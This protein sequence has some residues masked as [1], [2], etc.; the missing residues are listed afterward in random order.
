MDS[1]ARTSL[2]THGEAIEKKLQQNLAEQI[3]PSRL[4]GLIFGV[5]MRTNKLNEGSV[6]LLVGT[7]NDLKLSV[8]DQTKI[9]QSFETAL[10]QMNDELKLQGTK[11]QYHSL[12]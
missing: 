10:K 5:D 4:K 1:S 11:G 12:H 9:Q 8:S 6:K 2:A 7:G 3:E